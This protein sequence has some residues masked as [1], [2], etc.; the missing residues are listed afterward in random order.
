MQ[1][2]EDVQELNHTQKQGLQSLLAADKK[3]IVN[4]K[5]ETAEE[6]INKNLER[7]QKKTE[8]QTMVT[9]NLR[10]KRKM[11]K[12]Q[13]TLTNYLEDRN[14]IDPN[15]S[16]IINQYKIKG[17]MEFCDKK[18][19]H[20]KKYEA[21]ISI[22]TKSAVNQVKISTSQEKKIINEAIKE[23]KQYV[24]DR[25]LQH[26][27][28]MKDSMFAF[29]NPVT[30]YFK[31]KLSIDYET[32]T[33]AANHLIEILEKILENETVST[34]LSEIDRSALNDERLGVIIKKYSIDLK[35]FTVDYSASK[36]T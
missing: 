31:S 27:T 12:Y 9:Y 16:V 36:K 14:V 29:F 7:V 5:G 28:H 10:A 2:W 30:A 15:F 3:I 1:Q 18:I 24:L 21:S 20:Q 35:K 8:H 6:S 25:L 11:K 32:K 23:L 26:E 4:K 22:Q 13:A 19:K 17:L 33:K 34:T